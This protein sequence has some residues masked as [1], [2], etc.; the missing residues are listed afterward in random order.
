[1]QVDLKV[2]VLRLHI[3][4]TTNLVLLV[5]VQG[6]LAI[7]EDSVQHCPQAAVVDHFAWDA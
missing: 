6:D 5:L 3:N 7:S 2:N 1:M 4:N